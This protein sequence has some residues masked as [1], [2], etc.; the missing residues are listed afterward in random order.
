MS[1]SNTLRIC[2]WSGPRNV[3]T[4]LMY[5]FGNR[6]DTIAVDEPFYAHYLR[7]SD[8]DHPGKA[9]IIASMEP[10]AERVISDVI[11]GEYDQP[12]AMAGTV[13]G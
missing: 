13:G 9:E 3:S 6:E 7:V 5:S 8:V 1:S 2:S 4:A 11:F 12:I 10:Y